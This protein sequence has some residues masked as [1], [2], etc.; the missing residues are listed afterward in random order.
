MRLVLFYGLWFISCILRRFVTLFCMKPVSSPFLLFAGSGLLPIVGC[1]FY[2][3]WVAVWGQI[4]FFWDNVLLGSKYADHFYQNGW[5]NFLLP[6]PI[7]AGHPLLFAY[8]LALQWKVFGKTLWVSH[9]AVLPF[10]WGIVWAYWGIAKR[11]LHGYGLAAALLLLLADPALLAQ[12]IVGGAD[13]ALLCFFLWAV[14]GVI[15]G[16]RRLVALMLPLLCLVSLRGMILCAGIGI[17]HLLLYPHAK[18]QSWWARLTGLLPYYIPALLVSAGWLLYHYH[19][20]GFLVENHT[21]RHW[22]HHYQKAGI[23]FMVKN[24]IVCIWRLIDQGRVYMYVVTG[25][26]LVYLWRQN[27]KS[28]P[29]APPQRS[30]EFTYGNDR[31]DST[32][33]LCSLS[34]WLEGILTPFSAAQKQYMALVFTLLL[35]FLPFLVFRQMPL[36]HRYFMPFY[37]LVIPVFLLLTGKVMS[38]KGVKPI[39]LGAVVFLISGHFWLYPSPIANGWDATLACLP[40]F[41]AKNAAN[42]YII[43]QG[44]PPQQICTEFPMVSGARHTHLTEVNNLQL[45]AFTNQTLQTCNYVLYANVSNDFNAKELTLLYSDFIPIASFNHLWITMQLYQKK[46]PD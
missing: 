31:Q 30:G 45:T 6:L 11:L 4:P 35:C 10:L 28:S 14:Y 33:G 21:Y 40:Y 12:S 29:P 36:M 19:H 5:G 18:Q 16:N 37:A 17:G 24:A 46:K 34:R 23:L 43:Q 39:T 25:G 41:A 42:K 9:L 44:I 2:A 26:C 27:R 8:Y 13:V 32:N 15:S 38:P 22:W 3:C 20:T 7:D 1:G